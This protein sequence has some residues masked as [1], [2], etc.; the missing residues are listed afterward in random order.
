MCARGRGETEIST[1]GSGVVWAG[2]AENDASTEDGDA[3][4][5]EVRGVEDESKEE[6]KRVTKAN[7]HF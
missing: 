5:Q 4:L 7:E 6:L 2:S 3:E 1:G